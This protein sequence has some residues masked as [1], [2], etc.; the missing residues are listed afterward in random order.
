M[1]K[2]NMIVKFVAVGVSFRPA[3]RLYHTVKEET[4]MGKSVEWL[5]QR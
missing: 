1:L 4:G 3:R 2:V 5:N